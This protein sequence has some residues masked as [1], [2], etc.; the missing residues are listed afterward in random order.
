MKVIDLNETKSSIEDILS[1]A[2]SETVMVS[3]IDGVRYIVEE[4]DEFEREVAALGKSEKFMAFL[5]ERSEEK[6]GKSLDEIAK[7]LDETV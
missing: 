6:G 4:A 7:K 2:K 1:M 3:G 5:R